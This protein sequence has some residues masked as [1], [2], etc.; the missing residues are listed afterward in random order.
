MTTLPHPPNDLD[1]DTFA[2]LGASFMNAKVLCVGAEI[3]VFEHLGDGPRTSEEL[4]LVLNIPRRALR[5]VLNGL[6]AMGVLERRE[7][8]YSNGRAAQAFLAGKT[9]VDVRPGL[10]L[11]NQFMYPMWMGFENAVRTGQPARHGKPSE[12]FAKIFSEGVEAWTGPGA[13]ALPKVYD[14]SCHRR[15]LDLGGGTG[16]YLLPILAMHP[17]LRATLFE[18]PPSAVVARRRLEAEPVRDRIAIVEGD[19]LFD[20]LPEGHD[21]ALL[22]GFIHLFDPDKIRIILRRLRDAMLPGNMLIIVDQWMDSTHTKPTFGA[23]LAGTYLMLSG[24]GGTYS[25]DEARPWLAASGFGFLEH[26]ALAGVTSL[27]LAE[28]V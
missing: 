22:A 16:S 7:D 18:L 21:V 14:F 2:E 9:S 11:Y 24:D 26:R 20:P 17:E 13:R 1:P 15:L 12:E 3:G 28:A 23:M 10:R 25:A 8:R 6:A 27:I 5:V 4:A 19:A